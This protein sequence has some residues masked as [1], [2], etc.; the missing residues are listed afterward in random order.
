MGDQE[1]QHELL[2]AIGKRLRADRPLAIVDLE[3]TG[4][5]VGHDRIVEISIWKLHIDR[6]PWTVETWRSNR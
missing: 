5:L 1:P 3:T 6:E 2:I 4:L